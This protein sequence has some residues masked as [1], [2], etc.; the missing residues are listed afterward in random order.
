MKLIKRMKRGLI[1]LLIST[2]PVCAPNVF[3]D[4][5]IV[6]SSTIYQEQTVTD[7]QGSVSEQRAE[8]TSVRQGDELVLVITVE[9]QGSDDAV[10]IKVDNPVPDGTTYI[11]FSQSKNASV[12]LVSDNG[13][14]YF[15]EYTLFNTEL[16]PRDIR[17]V[18]W[19]IDH[20][21]ANDLQQ[22]EFKVTV[23]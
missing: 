15:P 4:A 8:A 20:L 13:E 14:D 17:F 22:M 19:V 11:G 18:R 6:I 2:T 21:E 23:N 10:N 9:N 5:E 3:A 7:E 12:Y 16:Q 1:G